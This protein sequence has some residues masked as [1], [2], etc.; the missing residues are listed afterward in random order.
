[1]EPAATATDWAMLAAW[2][3]LAAL[4]CLR[5]A[6]AIEL[7][8]SF[9]EAYYWLWSKHLAAGYYEHPAAIALAIRVGTSLFGN[10]ELGVRAP[11]LLFSLPASWAV[12]R[13]AAL[14]LADER[15]G[16][17]ACLLFNSTLMVAAETM[18]AT[19]DAFLI[20][21]ASL[22]LWSTAKLQISADGR[23]WLAV[24]AAAGFAISVKYTGFF[25]CGSLVLWLLAN[26]GAR[27]WL[28]TGWPYAGALIAALFFTPTLYWN[29]THGFASFDFQFGRMGAVHT[30]HLLEFLG[31]QIV[32]GSPFILVLAGL[33]LARNPLAT[34]RPRALS[35]A[36][37]IVWP[38]LLY[39][40]FHATHD[41]VQG[42]WP[43][44]VY[45]ALA[46]LA[47]QSLA[48][49]SQAGM[50]GQLLRLGRMLALPAAALIL[51][52]AYVQAFFG[53]FP[54][55][56][57][58]PIARM[59]GVGFLPVAETVAEDAARLN[60]GAIATTNYSTTAWLAYYARSTLP[61]VQIADEARLLSS[62]RATAADLAGT[63]LYVTANPRD[64]LPVVARH[65]S[66]I[67]FVA[68]LVR[69][70]NG[71]AIDSFYAY[72]ISG[73]HGA[74]VGRIP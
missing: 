33:G 43:C 45:P 29:A 2:A 20:A 11:A 65:F 57:H 7:P 73:F 46:L 60:A 26:N 37:A 47:A 69:A 55:G 22:L 49:G 61:V 54:I 74:V 17:L 63:L 21:A 19:P 66:Q 64:E 44:F 15:M 36:A 40:A 67:R 53:V 58:D 9:D 62:P 51:A 8:L 39:F 4:Y 32:L 28:R 25:L 13:S 71:D 56:R 50:S 59:T 68:R 35:F 30:N 5:L 70:R 6:L 3:A 1:M 42:N 41:R 52:V 48:K 34:E 10:S 14:L 38:A 24:G 16:A 18:G 72:R 27:I 31:G 12:W 23:W